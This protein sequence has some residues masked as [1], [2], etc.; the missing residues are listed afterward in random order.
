MNRFEASGPTGKAG[1]LLVPRSVIW[2]RSQLTRPEEMEIA[3]RHH[4]NTTIDLRASVF[5]KRGVTVAFKQRVELSLDCA[6]CGRTH[7]TVIFGPPNQLGL[8]TPS[9]HKFP[10]QISTLVIKEKR[11]LFRHEIECCIRLTYEYAPMSDKK[12]PH[13]VSSP[14]PTWGRICFTIKCPK[15]NHESENLLQNN[16]VRPWTCTCKC[17][18]ALYTEDREFPSFSKA[19]D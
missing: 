8:C 13:R 14:L 9:G 19:Y 5:P 17:G 12:Y 7:R 10:G 2:N 3:A 16:T 6:K 1:S 18:Y 4:M 15:C 11:R